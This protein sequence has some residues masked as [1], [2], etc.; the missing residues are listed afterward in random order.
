MSLKNK[1]LTAAALTVAVGAFSTFAAAQTNNGAAPDDNTQKQEQSERRG[2]GRRGDGM[3]GGHHGGGKFGMRGLRGI[4]LTDAQKEQVRNIMETNRTANQAVFEEF[5]TLRQAMRGGT[6]DATQ[7][8]RL[9][10]L[11]EQM[12]QNAEATRTQVL[13]ILTQEQRTQLEQQ[14]E[15]MRKRHEE[16]RQL[17]Q[18]R[19]APIT[20]TKEG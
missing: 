15:E 8:A 1:I 14:K 11:K 2:F 3:R 12:K 4:N 17:R 16:R 5:R 10:T 18:N 19:Q 6:L 7:Q 13:A 20:S 9:E